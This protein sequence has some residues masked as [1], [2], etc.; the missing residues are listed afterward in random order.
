MKMLEE[1]AKRYIEE[2]KFGK[3]ESALFYL[4]AMARP[5]ID[6]KVG[7]KAFVETEF[8]KD[9]KKLYS[10]TVLLLAEKNLEENLAW[11]MKGFVDNYTE[12]V[13]ALEQHWK[14]FYITSG[15]AFYGTLGAP[16]DADEWISASE[17]TEKWGLGESTLRS[18]ISRGKFESGE[19]RKSGSIW[20]VRESAM[21]RLYGEPKEGKFA[22]RKGQDG[23]IY[24]SA[25]GWTNAYTPD[26]EVDTSIEHQH[27]EE[28]P[29]KEAEAI[30]EDYGWAIC[31]ACGN[32]YPSMS[33]CS[34]CSKY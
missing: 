7:D 1:L 32:I 31:P 26:G 30:L 28:I 33:D 10:E 9:I 23:T 18:A 8:E 4:G 22:F 12:E 34:D 25:D 16:V 29:Q 11:A 20:L 15:A 13:E 14:Q 24:A 3:K 2:T 21:K 19:Y 17:A 5:L 27:G 6:T